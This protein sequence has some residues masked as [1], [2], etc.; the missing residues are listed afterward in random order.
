VQIWPTVFHLT[1]YKAG[2]QWI[3]HILKRCAP[4][5]VITPKHEIA[6]VMKDPIIAGHIYPT[7]YLTK[8]KFDQIKRPADSRFFVI[9]RDL[10]D[11][12]VSAYFS[13]K[14]SHVAMGEIP[15]IRQ[16]LCRRELESGLIWVIE[17]EIQS[18]ADIGRSWAESGEQWI[19][20]EDLLTR[21]VEILEDTLLK[22]CRLPIEEAV[23]RQAVL[24]CRFDQFSGGRRRGE[25]DIH[26]H[27]RK[28]VSGDWRQY[29]TKPAKAAF[30]ER[31]GDVL[32]ACA[33]EKSNDW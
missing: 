24:G 25:E 16:E 27:V 29:F 15:Q 4:E 9:L 26:S 20:Y 5:Q 18:S 14:I 21:D 22:K 12:T 10:R 30:K 28:G 13:L 8:E 31:F 23:L 19:R 7:V 33:Y 2:S 1:Q 17:N 6:H 32:I 11:I 3:Y